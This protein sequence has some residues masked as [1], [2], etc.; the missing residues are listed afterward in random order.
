MITFASALILGTGLIRR[1]P[2]LSPHMVYAD[3]KIDS[4]LSLYQIIYFG[5][6][7]SVFL[8]PILG[9]SVPFLLIFF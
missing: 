1:V 9:L 3:M 2:F 5:P 7:L 8:A 6:P 4:L